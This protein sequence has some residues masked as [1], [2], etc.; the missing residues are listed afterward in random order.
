MNA[1]NSIIKDYTEGTK[2]LEA[3]NE[4]LQNAGAKFRFEP[5]KNE[6]KPGEEYRYGLLDTGTGPLDKVEVRD[7]KLVYGIGSMMGLLHFHGKIYR[8]RDRELDPV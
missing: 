6:I 8:V 1:I 2:D 4:A 3:T 7:G 5:G